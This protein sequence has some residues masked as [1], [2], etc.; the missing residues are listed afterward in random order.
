MRKYKRLCK[1]AEILNEEFKSN[2]DKSRAIVI[3]VG[4][5]YKIAILKVMSSKEIRRI[6]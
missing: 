5:K 6:K 3:Q 1:K 4:V 2:G